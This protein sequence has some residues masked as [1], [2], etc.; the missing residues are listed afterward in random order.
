MISVPPRRYVSDLRA[1][2]YPYADGRS[3]PSRMNRLHRTLD[4]ELAAV[5]ARA[6][7]EMSRQ[8]RGDTEGQDILR[9]VG[10]RASA[11]RAVFAASGGGAR[12][13]KKIS[14]LHKMEETV[15]IALGRIG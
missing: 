7:V 3:W 9:A 13:M 5:A 12:S 4:E 6:W 11:A 2:R 8:C 15:C 10:G 1:G 14:T